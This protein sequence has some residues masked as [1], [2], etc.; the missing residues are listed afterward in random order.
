MTIKL[1]KKNLLQSSSFVLQ[2]TLSITLLITT[3]LKKLMFIEYRWNRNIS[4]P[5][6]FW[7]W[8]ELLYMYKDLVKKTFTELQRLLL[9]MFESKLCFCCYKDCFFMVCFFLLQFTA[10]EQ[11]GYVGFANLP[12]QV[13]RKSVKKGFEFTL[14]VVGK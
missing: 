1:T 8:I 13:H 2:L 7:P 12:N 14:M 4:I 11:S 9:W 5:W 3:V 10:P 6:L